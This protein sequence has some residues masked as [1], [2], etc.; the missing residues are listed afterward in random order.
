MKKIILSL[1][2]IALSITPSLS[3]AYAEE[4]KG[5]IHSMSATELNIMDDNGK[6]TKVAIPEGSKVAEGFTKHENVIV[7]V[8]NGKAVAMKKDT[9]VEEDEEGMEE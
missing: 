1:A 7:T 2:L 4:L 9:S 3:T 5:H 6:T 8:E